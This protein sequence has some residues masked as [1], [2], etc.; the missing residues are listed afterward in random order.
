MI[1]QQLGSNNHFAKPMT[2]N[3][4]QKTA[5]SA[6]VADGADLGVIQDRLKEEFELNLTYLDTRFLLG[7]LGLELVSEI[8]DTPAET[9][10]SA[11]PAAPPTPGDGGEGSQAGGLPVE[12]T[13]PAPDAPTPPAGNISVT[14]DS[15]T[16]PGSV[17]SGKVTFSDGVKADWYLD[18]M[19]RLG[20]DPSQEGYQPSQDDIAVFQVELQNVL[21]Q[22]GF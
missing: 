2:L 14:V 19:G 17:V 22:Q 6:W 3:D 21:R 10:S 12:D 5:L 15:L 18:Q 16:Q 11:P 7:D 8:E 20:L 4:E 1:D 9:Q 13:P